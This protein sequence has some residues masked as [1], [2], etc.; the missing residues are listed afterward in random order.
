MLRRGTGPLAPTLIPTL[1]LLLLRLSL[2]PAAAAYV[3]HNTAWQHGAECINNPGS[4][5]IE[6][7]GATTK[8][9]CA[10]KCAA[11][12]VVSTTGDVC[13]YW[14]GGSSSICKL[15]TD[16]SGTPTNTSGGSR[17]S[18]ICQ[19]G[20]RGIAAACAPSMLARTPPSP[21]DPWPVSFNSLVG[22]G[23][24]LGCTA[25]GGMWLM[26]VTGM[27]FSHMADVSLLTAPAT[28]NQCY[29]RC[30]MTTGSLSSGR[31]C[32]KCD[33]PTLP[34][35]GFTLVEDTSRGGKLCVPDMCEGNNNPVMC[36]WV[37]SK[38]GADSCAW[39]YWGGADKCTSQAT[40]GLAH[41]T[42]NC[43]PTPTGLPANKCLDQSGSAATVVG[44]VHGIIAALV[45]Q[46]EET[47]K[48]ICEYSGNARSG[49]GASWGGV[50][51][52]RSGGVG[53]VPGLLCCQYHADTSSCTVH[54][55]DAGR[56]FQANVKS[57]CTPLS[58]SPSP[59]PSASAVD[60]RSVSCPVRQAFCS[61]WCST[62]GGQKAWAE[63][64]KCDCNNEHTCADGAAT[65]TAT[66]SSCDVTGCNLCPVAG[67]CVE[68]SGTFWLSDDKKSCAAGPI[69]YPET[70]TTDCSKVTTLTCNSGVFS[71]KH[72][73][74]AVSSLLPAE[75]M[76]TTTGCAPLGGGG[77]TGGYPAQKGSSNIVG[78]SLGSGTTP[79]ILTEA[80]FNTEFD[81]MWEACNMHQYC[82]SSSLVS[83]RRQRAGWGET[84]I[85][86]QLICIGGQT[87]SYI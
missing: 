14:K 32:S 37:G 2:N 58:T 55:V 71:P 10:D 22:C 24:A 82:Y 86:I 85:D 64:D 51:M 54:Q 61:T 76:G 3:C 9:E 84:R 59:S 25:G 74:G 80:P 27:N 18:L 43:T 56:N 17:N 57:V 60:T 4:S 34:N 75:A 13:C 38:Q 8:A 26:F 87:A 35:T 28:R 7:N 81:S 31:V 29:A 42:H 62:K 63:P 12:T 70:P 44:T 1:L 67:E 69:T 6:L 79:W 52:T 15:F 5:G 45:G 30:A 50:D 53:S 19:V 23:D 39:D 40:L 68:C 78:F 66:S 47:C 72:K 83:T 20:Y 65:V 49:P 77:Y 36:E 73:Y 48:R 21:L 33:D 16:Y 41:R 46:G 11:A